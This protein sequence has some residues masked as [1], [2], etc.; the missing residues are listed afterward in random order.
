MT[1]NKIDELLPQL[2]ITLRLLH[3]AEIAMGPGKAQLLEAIQKTGSISAAGKSMNMSYRRAWVLVDVMNHSF[4]E[5]LV[6]T[7]KGGKHGGGASL[8]AMGLRVLDHYQKMNQAVAHTAQAYLPL[9]SGL[10]LNTDISKDILEEGD[11]YAQSTQSG[12]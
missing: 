4:T 6:Q 3:N 2:K 1:D 10:M 11:E 7:A 12:D 9:F 8:T 5:P